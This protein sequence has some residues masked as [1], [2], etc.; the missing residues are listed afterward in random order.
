MARI[1]VETSSF[2]R[3]KHISL[4]Y[5]SFWFNIKGFLLLQQTLCVCVGGHDAENA[6]RLPIPHLRTLPMTRYSCGSTDSK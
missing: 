5:F 6:F 2:K 4:Q 3:Q 1:S